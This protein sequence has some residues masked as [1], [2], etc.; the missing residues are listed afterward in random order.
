M[1][2]TAPAAA[3]EDPG[4]TD[5]GEK[6]PETEEPDAA[7]VIVWPTV[8]LTTD[9]IP[10]YGMTWGELVKLGDDGSAALGGEALEGFFAINKN[11][12]A[13]PDINDSFAVVFTYLDGE[14]VKTLE[15]D[16]YAVTLARKPIDAS[17]VILSPVEMQYA[18]GEECRPA[19][20]LRDGV[21]NLDPSKDF[22]VTGYA[23][24][25]EIGTGSVT[26]EGRG[27]YRDTVTK[28]FVISPIPVSALSGSI[29]SCK[30]EDE[31]TR[32]AIVF[33][34]GERQLVEGRDYEL[35]LSY[36]I[37]ART[38]TASASFKGIYSGTRILSFDLPNY[39]ITEGAGSIWKKSSYEDLVFK[40]NGA[41]V[42][43]TELTVDGRTVPTNYYSLESGS[44]IVKVRA[45]YLKSLTA[46]KHIIG[47]AYQDGKALAIFS[48]MDVQ[49]RGVATGDSNNASAW[50]IVLIASVIAFGA[51][52]FAFIRSGKKKKKKK[53]T[54]K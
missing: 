38:G 48:V 39:L 15:S 14:E 27:N 34:H 50:I 49:R 26:V 40:A 30:P 12:S 24:N 11:S 52:A 5:E 20:S 32:P 6:A 35:S 47:V 21:N 31:S 18:Y 2:L 1:G 17:M 51:L 7:P 45:D 33:K 13:L 42:K 9:P 16:E 23:D 36:D 4:Q 54:K 29:T 41:L 46:G 37:P 3:E 43:F 44:T 10:V 25:K 8:S 53:R 19:V 28:Y 22:T